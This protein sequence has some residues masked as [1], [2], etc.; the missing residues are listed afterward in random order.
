MEGWCPASVK[1]YPFGL[2]V[3]PVVASQSTEGLEVEFNSD[4]TAPSSTRTSCSPEGAEW[5][6][7]G[8]IVSH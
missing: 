4:R 3:L 8:S 2:T 6:I 5:G 7:R 1:V